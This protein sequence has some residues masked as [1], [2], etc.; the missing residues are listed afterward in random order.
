MLAGIGMLENQG[1]LKTAVDDE[2]P[3]L[4]DPPR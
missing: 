1:M 4:E 2:S 3:V